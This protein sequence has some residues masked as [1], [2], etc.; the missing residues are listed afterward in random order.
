MWVKWD[1]K[2]TIAAS[3]H[4]TL[5]DRTPTKWTLNEVENS[6]ETFV[7]NKVIHLMQSEPKASV[8]NLYQNQLASSSNN[9]KPSLV[10]PTTTEDKPF[11]SLPKLSKHN[12]QT[13]ISFQYQNNEVSTIIPTAQQVISG[14]ETVN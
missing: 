2:Y 11:S 1:R 14:V 12:S 3:L 8:T 13:P 5:L 10:P 4:Q 7:S 6:N 9:S